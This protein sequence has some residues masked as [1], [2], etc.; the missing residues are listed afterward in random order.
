MKILKKILLSF[1]ICGMVLST[2]AMQDV[3]AAT[4]VTIVKKSLNKKGIE[5]DGLIMDDYDSTTITYNV[6]STTYVMIALTDWSDTVNYTITRNDGKIVSLPDSK[7]FYDDELG[8][9]YIYTTFT[10]G[11]NTIYVGSTAAYENNEEGF[12]VIKYVPISTIGNVKS[13]YTIA[14]KK[15]GN[16]GKLYPYWVDGADLYKI[17]SKVS[18]KSSNTKI[19]Y[20]SATGYLYTKGIGTAYITI[21]APSYYDSEG[22]CVAKAITKKVKVTSKLQGVSFTVNNYKRRKLQVKIKK[23]NKNASGYQIQIAKNKKFTSGRKTYKI[24]STSSSKTISKLRKKSKYYT[25]VRSYKIIGKKTYYSN[26][27]VAKGRLTVR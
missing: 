25:R 8:L 14:Y 11:N 13:S 18:F 4:P 26:W 9:Y 2:V 12:A 16:V 7:W 17:S 21:S 22:M 1:A 23:R 15:S 5:A 19:I 20:T 24:K 27:V 3:K 6:S 10:S